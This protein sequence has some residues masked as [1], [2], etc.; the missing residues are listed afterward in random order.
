M[1]HRSDMLQLEEAL[2]LIQGAFKMKIAFWK[3]ERLAR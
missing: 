2:N 1:R 3:S